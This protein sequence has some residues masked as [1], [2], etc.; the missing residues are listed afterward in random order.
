MELFVPHEVRGR[1]YLDQEATLSL[2]N[3]VKKTHLEFV[4]DLIE[5]CEH[6]DM[7]LHVANVVDLEL[8]LIEGNI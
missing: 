7:G 2:K 4:G 8:N 6:Q 1:V 3:V 5:S